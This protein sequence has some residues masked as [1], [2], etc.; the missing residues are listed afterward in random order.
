MENPKI[1]EA[2]EA[3]RRAQ[4]GVDPP[5][6]GSPSSTL[7][8]PDGTCINAKATG[9]PNAK[10]S[11]SVLREHLPGPRPARRAILKPLR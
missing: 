7:K 10:S 3:V 5:G 9:G 8:E 2:F 11:G 6:K 4:Q 1:A